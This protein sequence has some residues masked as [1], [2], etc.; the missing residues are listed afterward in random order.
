MRRFPFSVFPL[1]FSPPMSTN[2]HL[3]ADN[4]I[5]NVTI[6]DVAGRDITSEVENHYGIDSAQLLQL[7]ARYL[8]DRERR[9]RRQD[10]NIANVIGLLLILF[11]VVFLL[12]FGRKWR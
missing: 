9:S 4:S 1:R 6:R 12:V 3:G 10:T 5:G 2:L 8:D 11:I 7:L